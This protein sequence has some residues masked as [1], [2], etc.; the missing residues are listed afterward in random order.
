MRFSY[1]LILGVVIWFS[2]CNPSKKEETKSV[3]KEGKFNKTE[4]GQC[5][6]T[7]SSGTTV[8][9]DL[10][11]PAGSDSASTKIRSFLSRKVIERVNEQ[12]DSASIAAI[13]GADKDLKAAYE[14]FAGNY[15]KLKAD[16][17][18]APGCWFIE[19]KGDTVMISDKIVQYQLDHFAFTGGAHPN[20]FRSYYI[21]DGKTGVEKNAK[22]FIADSAALLKKAEHAFRKLEKIEDTTNLEEAGYFLSDHKFFLPA[23]YA[24]TKEGVF[25]Y[26]NPYEIAAYARGAITFTIPYEELEGI[27][28]KELIL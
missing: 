10:W 19:V 20:S 12:G 26:Y 6:T 17:P 27:V 24:F 9:V 25:F 4:F 22:S 13:P 15:K 23:N 16:F 28:K 11:E 18:D 5:D 21:F 7:V 14:V 1:F 3:V 8:K 2:S